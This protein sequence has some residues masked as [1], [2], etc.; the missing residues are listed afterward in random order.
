MRWARV[1]DTVQEWSRREPGL[2]LCRL[3]STP[4]PGA[5][6]QQVPPTE[7][8][9]EDWRARARPHAGAVPET[10][11][12]GSGRTLA[13]QRLWPDLP[14][15]LAGIA[16]EEEWGPHGPALATGLAQWWVRGDWQAALLEGRL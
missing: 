6:E 13:S 3:P 11:P 5:S 14:L 10:A 15:P 12:D 4:F 1:R 8:Q 2:E 16:M 7:E 9:R